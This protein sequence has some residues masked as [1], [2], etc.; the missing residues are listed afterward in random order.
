V[1]PVPI[2]K[3]H[4]DA[5]WIFVQKWIDAHLTNVLAG[6][7][8]VC[9]VFLKYNFSKNII[10]RFSNREIKTSYQPCDRRIASIDGGRITSVRVSETVLFVLLW[11]FKNT[12][13]NR[14]VVHTH[15][16]AWWD[17]QC[18]VVYLRLIVSKCDNSYVNTMC[19]QQRQHK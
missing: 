19:T 16:V 7:I 15:T 4:K 10:S 3:T 12:T 13:M 2:V 1:S 18:C 9:F 8:Y 17:K 5:I 11:L 14:S 6:M